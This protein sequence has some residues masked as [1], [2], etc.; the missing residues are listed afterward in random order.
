MLMYRTNP[1]GSGIAQRRRNCEYVRKRHMNLALQRRAKGRLEQIRPGRCPAAWP[2]ASLLGEAEA[3]PTEKYAAARSDGSHIGKAIK[4]LVRL[5]IE[6]DFT[7]QRAADAVGIKRTS[8]YRHLHK[9]HVVAYRREQRA[10]QVEL[11]STR[12]PKKLSGLMDSE[13]HAAAVRAALALE[14]LNQQSRAEPAVRRISTGGIVIVLPAPAQRALP[15]MPTIEMEPADA[16]E[17]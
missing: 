6:D 16:E 11:L 7:W 9:A 2:V 10:Q 4:E 1:S 8:A 13:N 14:D 15:S 12:V 3:M 17:I 5:M